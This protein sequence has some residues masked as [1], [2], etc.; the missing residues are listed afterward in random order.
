MRRLSVGSI[1]QRLNAM[2]YHYCRP[3]R[4][5]RLT[6]IHRLRRYQWARQH[7]VSVIRHWRYLIFTDES[8]I[9]LFHTTDGLG[10]VGG[11]MRG[12]LLSVC[13]EQMVMSVHLSSYGLRFTMMARKKTGCA[14]W[15][16]EPASVHTCS[17]AK[18]P[19]LGKIHLPEKLRPGPK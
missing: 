5:P 14:G 11:K 19:T 12:T 13:R 10:Y 7:C 18:S 15:L 3:T 4:C 2:E 9:K 1:T 17:V 16:H 6:L 8:K